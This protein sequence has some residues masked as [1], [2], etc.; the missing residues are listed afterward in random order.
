MG[1]Q[2]GKFETGFKQRIVQEVDSGLG[3]VGRR[4]PQVPDLGSAI[5]RWRRQSR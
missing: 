2:S 1:K 5:D 3:S 4:Q